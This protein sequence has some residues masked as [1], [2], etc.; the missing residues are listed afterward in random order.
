MDLD[1][2]G[3]YL[4]YVGNWTI[5]WYFDLRHFLPRVSLPSMNYNQKNLS[6]SRNFLTAKVRNQ[7]AFKIIVILPAW[8]YAP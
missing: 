6:N 1:A 5:R 8:F 2:A 4:Y 7:A 3:R